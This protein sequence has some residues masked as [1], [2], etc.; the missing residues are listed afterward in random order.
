MSRGRSLGRGGGRA[1]A[2]AGATAPL[3]GGQRAVWMGCWMDGRARGY[4]ER[5]RDSDE[6]DARA[7]RGRNALLPH[8]CL[9]CWIP[10]WKIACRRPARFLSASATIAVYRVWYGHRAIASWRPAAFCAQRISPRFDR[11]CHS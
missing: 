4:D 3:R 11:E 8:L 7:A 2:A 1:R 5:F 6:I 9:L 10:G